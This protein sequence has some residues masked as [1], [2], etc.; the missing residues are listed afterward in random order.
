MPGRPRTDEQRAQARASAARHRAKVTRL[1][2]EAYGNRCA[3]CGEDHPIFLTLDHVNGGGR[4]DLEAVGSTYRLYARVI[5]EGFPSQYQ[6]LCW[7][8]NFAKHA[9]GTCPHQ[10]ESGE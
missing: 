8:C 4:I 7:N 2:R 1:V 5:R 9:L 3:C 6:L 10:T